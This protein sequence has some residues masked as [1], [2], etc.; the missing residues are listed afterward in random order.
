MIRSG[1]RLINT[2]NW[3]EL[4]KPRQLVRDDKSTSTYGKFICEPLER[5]YGTTLGNALRRV[6]LSSLQGAAIVAAKIRGVAHEFTTIPGVLEDVTDIILNLKQVRFEMT[7]DEPQHLQLIANEKG[8]VTAGDIKE[9]ASVKVLN[10]DLHIA[11]L[12]DDIDFVIDLEVRMGKGYVPA[13]L[14]A[15]L[16]DEIGIIKL[17]ASFS[18]VKKVAF[19][20]EQARVGQLTNYDKLILE[21]WTDGSVLP[22]DALAYSAKILQDQLTIFIN[23]DDVDSGTSV[24]SEEKKEELNEY[25]FKHIDELELPPRANNCLKSVGITLVGELVQ[26]TENELL[27]IKN[28]GR[29]SLDD[30]W[31]VLNTLGLEF[32]MKID[33]FEEKYKEW[34]KRKEKD[35]A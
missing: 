31:R 33:N 13:E 12:S 32:G 6:L 27:K 29:K 17:D 14:H 15:G 1:D 16:D 21:I 7:T 2:R 20:V 18:P 11:T 9:T 35:E 5:G 26:K 8:E 24:E 19:D 10:P 34:L 28:F 22:E 30:I 3:T 25:L 23:F 4:V